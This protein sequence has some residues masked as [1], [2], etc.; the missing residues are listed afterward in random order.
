MRGSK[1]HFQNWSGEPRN[2]FIES[3]N[4]LLPPTGAQLGPEDCWVPCG[5]QNPNEAQLDKVEDAFLEI[6]IREQ[7]AGWWLA[8]PGR[9]TPNWDLVCTCSLAGKKGLVLLEGKAHSKELQDK[10]VCGAKEPNRLQIAAALAAASDSLNK[11]WS[12]FNLSLERHYQLANRLAWSWKLASLGIPIVLIYLGF[13]GDEGMRDVGEPLRDHTHW[14][15]LM[16]VY[17]QGVAPEAALE[18]QIKCGDAEFWFLIRSLPVP[19]PPAQGGK[20][21]NS[22][23]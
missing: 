10:D 14:N 16:R 15:N 22:G 19:P 6:P 18:R 21:R 3:L 4:Q 7:L 8:T 1:L 12:G 11:H 20:D 23:K 17:M 5:S 9:E 2:V 13:L